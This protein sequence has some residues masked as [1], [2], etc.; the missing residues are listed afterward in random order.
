MVVSQFT[1][2]GV[3]NDLALMHVESRREVRIA[4]KTT[5]LFRWSGGRSARRSVSP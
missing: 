4:R 5:F 3:I 1:G 2:D